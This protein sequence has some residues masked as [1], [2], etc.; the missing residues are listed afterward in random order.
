MIFQVKILGNNSAVPAHDRNQTSQ[1]VQ[2]DSQFIL[3]DCGEATQIQL[4]RFDIRIGRIK[5][6][7]ISHLHG[8]H[9]FGLI[10]LISTMHLFQRTAP[11][12]IFS[13]PGLEEIIRL[14]LNVSSTE[15]SF[16]LRFSQ[17]FHEGMNQILDEND[18]TISAFPLRHGISCYGFLI[19][20]KPKPWRIRK[21]CLPDDILIQEIV[22]LK[23][24]RDVLDDD[25]NVK[26]ACSEFTL[27][28]KPSRSFAYCSDTAFDTS[29]LSYIQGVDLL[30]H[31]ATFTSDM[32][33]RAESTFH[34]TAAQA[35]TIASMAGVGKLLLG[36]YSTRYKE[37]GPLLEEA[38]GVFAESYLSIEGETIAIKE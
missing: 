15:L 23:N 14:Q 25:G 18:F 30:Y 33:D 21:D 6:I 5:T 1:L 31:E 37:L 17:L 8:D 26:Y 27:S 2:L 16:P 28:P 20:E 34:S 10:G 35:A 3:I 38:R 22:K 29:I 11:L 36:H 32:Q 12:Q 9:Y 13:P 7:L 24:G 19:K 4:S